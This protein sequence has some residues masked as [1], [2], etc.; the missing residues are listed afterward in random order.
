VWLDAY[1]QAW[2]NQDPQAAANIFAANATYQETPFDEQI[3]GREAILQYWLEETYVQKQV[4]F[5]YEILAVG[6]NRGIARWQ[7]SFARIPSKTQVKFDGIF[8]VYLNANNLCTVFEEWWNKE[9][10]PPQ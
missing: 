4:K 1:G 2:E 3:R 9:E 5:S 8:V 10:K 7:A 6:E